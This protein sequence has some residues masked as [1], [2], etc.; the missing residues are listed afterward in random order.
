MFGEI[1]FTIPCAPVSQ[2]A[3]RAAKERFTA[4]VRKITEPLE[5]LL[6]GEIRL[7]I[8]WS[9]SEYDRWETPDAPDVDNILKPLLDAL[10]GPQGILLDDCQV[11]ALGVSWLD[12]TLDTQSVEILL[13]FRS[14]E[15]LRKEGLSFVRFKDGLCFPIPGDIR[16]SHLQPWLQAAEAAVKLRDATGRIARSILHGNFIHRSRLTEFP[17]FS[18][19]ELREEPLQ[20]NI[21]EGYIHTPK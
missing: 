8:V 21:H 10:C 11:Q 13:K 2:Q 3:T 18:L 12:W 7:E 16:K 20:K 5:Y 4:E 14:D 1:Q 15:F 6:D 19:E 17:V 9:I